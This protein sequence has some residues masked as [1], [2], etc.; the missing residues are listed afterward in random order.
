MA[1]IP[2]F[3]YDFRSKSR[4]QNGSGAYLTGGTLKRPDFRQDFEKIEKTEKFYIFLQK[5]GNLSKNVIN[6]WKF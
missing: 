4:T 2:G 5:S 1:P 6:F 3:L